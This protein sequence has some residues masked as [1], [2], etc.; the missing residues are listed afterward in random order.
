MIHRSTHIINNNNKRESLMDL[1]DD[2]FNRGEMVHS[3]IINSNNTV[4]V[5]YVKQNEVS[6]R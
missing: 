4:T 5:L 2:F 6:E 3:Y 1:M